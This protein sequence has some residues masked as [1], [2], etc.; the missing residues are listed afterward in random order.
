MNNQSKPLVSVIVSFLNE[1]R[2]LEEAIQSVLWQKYSNWE[3]ILIDDGSS[4]S[5]SDIAKKYAREYPDK[6]YY[7]EHENHANKGLSGSRNYG[8]SKSKGDLIAILD[9]DDV[10]LPDKLH[11]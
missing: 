7:L 6:I 3:L 5:S 4:D 11:V 2:F 9:A 1:E 10:W 8:I